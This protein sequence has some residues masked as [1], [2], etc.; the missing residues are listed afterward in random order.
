MT[1]KEHFHAILKKES[2]RPGFWHGYPNSESTE[3]LYSYFN[4]KNDFELGL[5]LNSVLR[6]VSPEHCGFWKRTDYP[7]FDPLNM[8]RYKDKVRTSLGM[9]GVFAECEDTG[10][11]HDYHWPRTEDLDFSETLAEIDKTVEAGQAVLSG[12]W[13]S[14]FSNTWNYFGMENCFVKMHTH[15]ELVEAVTRHITDFYLAAN[16]QLFALAGNKIDAVF[17]GVD[18]G[19][20]LD[21]LISPECF[22]RFLFPYLKELIDQA[23]C[24]GYFLVLHSCGSIYRI[25]PALIDAG[26]DMLHPIQALARNMDAKTLA[27]CYNGKIVF[28]GGVD[29]QR[30]L[31]FSNS[32]EVRKEV[33]RLRKLFGP[34]YIVSPSH[35]SILPN[36]KPENVEAMAEAACELNIKE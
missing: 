15:P 1:G 7:M 36:V 4:V 22:E 32:G 17:I 18:M 14:I 3:R 13:G 10:E 25:I 28:L 23:H 35:E 21:L 26:V 11:I 19:S 2:D 29:T 16:E 9:A 24:H 6:W 33:L 20:Q 34:N 12:A 5:Q 8:A 31:P 27:G 30:I